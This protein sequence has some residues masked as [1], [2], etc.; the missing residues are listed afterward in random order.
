MTKE[1]LA[2]ICHYLNLALVGGRYRQALLHYKIN[3]IE[4]QREMFPII[5]D[6]FK[7]LLD[8]NDAE[9][10]KLIRSHQDIHWHF[11]TLFFNGSLQEDAGPEIDLLPAGE[12][13]GPNL[14]RLID[15]AP[16]GRVVHCP[17]CNEML[18]AFVRY[19][20][21]S[22]TQL[23]HNKEVSC[24]KCGAT[25]LAV[26]FTVTCVKNGNDRSKIPSDNNDWPFI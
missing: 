22:D 26:G 25:W 17:K 2:E 8:N 10:L 13:S 11:Q 5:R 4:V 7:G 23:K 9:R 16:D 15:A 21:E 6:H 18:M 24:P 1:K 12:I 20:H 14:Y 3:G 19:N